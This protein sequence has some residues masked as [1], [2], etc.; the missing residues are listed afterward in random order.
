MRY[1]SSI[2]I[3][4]QESR[5]SINVKNLVVAVTTYLVYQNIENCIIISGDDY[6]NSNNQSLKLGIIFFY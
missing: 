6:F 3:E 4:L 5:A 2:F 1:I